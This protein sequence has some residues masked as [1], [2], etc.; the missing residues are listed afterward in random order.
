MT[1]KVSIC[2]PNLNTRPY[3]PERFETIFNQTLQDWELLV[4]DSYSDDGAWEYIQELAAREPRMRIWQGPR[5][6]TPGSWNPCIQEAR[7]EFVYIATSDDTMMPDCLERMVRALEKNPQCGVCQCALEVIDSDGKP[8]PSMRWRDFA[9]GRFAGDW[10]DRPHV[11]QAPLDGI[12]HFALQTVYTSI[13]QVLL[14]RR[15]FDRVGLFDSR[16]GAKGDF[17]WGARVGLLE[18]CVYLPEVLATWRVHPQQAT[19]DTE[20]ASTRQRLHEMC[21]AA[22]VRARNVEPSLEKLNAEQL[23]RFYNE[24]IIQFQLRDIPDARRRMQWLINEA[25][26]GNIHALR[27]VWNRLCG[28]RFGEPYQFQ[29]LHSLLKEL[30]VPAPVFI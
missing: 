30:D 8:H 26:R 7:G 6:G 27:R 18:S 5:M 4:Y 22:L 16:F 12:L 9:F 29:N 24:Q 15:V 2:V 20:S 28:E 21:E 17:E 19:G 10:L 14:R 1:P 23:L 3:L 11:R 25:M 13:T